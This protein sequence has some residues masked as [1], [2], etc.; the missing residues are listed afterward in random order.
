MYSWFP[1]PY[2]SVR[3]SP[4]LEP[5]RV[6]GV[7]ANQRGPPRSEQP[8][9]ITPPA[10]R[11]AFVCLLT[12]FPPFI[13][14]PVPLL[15]LSTDDAAATTS[16]STP[17]RS[18]SRSR[19]A[20]SMTYCRHCS[21]G[22]TKKAKFSHNVPSATKDQ[23]GMLGLTDKSTLRPLSKK[24]QHSQVSQGYFGQSLKRW[25]CAK[26]QP[27][28]SKSNDVFISGVTGTT[29][30]FNRTA[31]ET[32]SLWTIVMCSLHCKHDRRFLLHY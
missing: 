21:R 10:D 11:E 22:L 23:N 9:P 2:A 5:T 4:L 20:N 3:P 28:S 24:S 7:S 26:H 14:I 8:H 30:S 12:L 1:R 31:K 29:S 27:I 17:T 15:S 13:P 25:D 19:G 18:S 16:P 6:S 32:C